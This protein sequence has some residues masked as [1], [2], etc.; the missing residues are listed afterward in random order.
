MGIRMA[1]PRWRGVGASVEGALHTHHGTV[2]QDAVKVDIN[3]HR[4]I[5]CVADGHGDP[6]H[7]RSDV[8]SK[9]AV[10]VAA[11]KLAELARDLAQ[12]GSAHPLQLEERLRD[13]LGHRVVWEWNRRARTHAEQLVAEETGVPQGEG[14]DGTWHSD[15]TLYGTTLLC[16]MF[17]QRL[18]IYLQ[19]GDGDILYLARDGS[20]ERMFPVEAELMGTATWSMCQQ[21]AVS[22]MQL[23]CRQMGRSTPGLV[24]LTTDGV[25]DSLADSFEAYMG[26][27]EWL[28][29]RVDSLGLDAVE[30]ELPVWLRQLSERGNGDDATL[31]FVHW[32]K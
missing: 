7:A 10:E 29:E 22:R 11:E 3:A 20:A 2:C 19:L 17:T 31:G 24:M 25:R 1:L 21:D 27:G 14:P 6:R 9:M 30:A 8:G 23:M 5:V 15:L 26:V 18:A 12:E 28:M 32:A 13:H 4:A 16:A